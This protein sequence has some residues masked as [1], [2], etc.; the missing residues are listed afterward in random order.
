VSEIGRALRASR[1]P[2]AALLLLGAVSVVA[3]P[4]L[5]I[6]ET[7]AAAVAWEMWTTPSRLVPL[8]NGEPYSHKPPVLAWT[9]FAGWAVAGVT[10]AWV[11]LVP[12]LFAAAS[13]ALVAALARR[14][15]P[16]DREAPALASWVLVGC[17]LFSVLGTSLLYDAPLACFALLALLGIVLAAESRWSGVVLAGVAIG[18]GILTKGPVVLV[19]VLPVALLAPWWAGAA[20]GPLGR[21]AAK[22]AAMLGIG[23][24]VALAWALPA[25]AAGGE[26]YRRELL[27]GQTAGRVVEAF[28][29]RKPWWWY[30]PFLPVVV[31]PWSVWPPLWR[32]AVRV[33]RGPRDRGVRFALAVVVPGVAVMSSVSGKQ[34]YYLLPLV[35]AFALMA[36]RALSAQP[37]AARRWHAAVP[38]SLLAATG[39]AVALAGFGL[40]ETEAL[41]GVSPWA[42]V[43][44]VLVALAPV[45]RR[46]AGPAANARGLAVAAVAWLALMLVAF[47]PS[48]L[49]A[50]QDLRP[51]SLVLAEAQRD[52]R[53]VAHAGNYE[54]QYQFLGRLRRPLE[55]IPRDE[56]P[57]WA[58][59]HGDG[60]VLLYTRRWPADV[61]GAPLFAG[62]YRGQFATLWRA[63][64]VTAELL[65][66]LATSS[67]A[68]R[69]GAR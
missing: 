12:M 28:S 22:V 35:P 16:G 46:P 25:A 37:A 30:L 63:G 19:A 4:L 14:L 31:F 59:S 65:A 43:A 40:P 17:L 55:V 54:G 18:L 6:D 24:L 68:A 20:V 62:R 15:W 49:L 36:A 5:P 57:R 8:Q 32:A 1:G 67:G 2:L 47:S 60:V 56:A 27:W 34:P 58:G 52:G 45:A 69:S 64:D 53:P 51:L 42:G 33:A 26:A 66:G 39:L 3:R 38:S 29:H 21:W 48:A 9:I 61:R 11:R 23:A 10:E 50:A 44:A 13:L 7:R 41:A